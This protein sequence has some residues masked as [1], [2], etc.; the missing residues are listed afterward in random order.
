MIIN[1]T[2]RK[3]APP[4]EESRINWADILIVLKHGLKSRI[5]E[6]KKIEEEK[7]VIEVEVI[8]E[9]PRAFEWSVTNEY[10]LGEIIPFTEI[11]ESENKFLS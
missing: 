4:R 1:I 10:R 2:N 11:I 7:A 9:E 6:A 3:F 8:P 5:S